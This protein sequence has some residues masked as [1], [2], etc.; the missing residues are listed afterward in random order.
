MEDLNLETQATQQKRFP[1]FQ[2]KE[3]L[4]KKVKV[5]PTIWDKAFS[6]R[7]L[8]NQKKVA[9]LYLRDSGNAET[10]EIEPKQGFFSIRGKTYHERRDCTYVMGK[11]RFP[12]AIIPESNMVPIGK[13]EWYEK[14]LQETFSNLQDHLIKGLRHAERVRMGESNLDKQLNMK[15]VIVWGLL[16]IIVVAVLVGYVG[17]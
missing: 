1:I 17:K 11:E 15:Q 10:Y 7:K 12:L 5:K 2:K 4:L 16:G 14:S 13:K 9:V 8:K 3:E 6:K